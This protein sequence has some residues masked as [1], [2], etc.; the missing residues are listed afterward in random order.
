MRVYYFTDGHDLS[1]FSENN[2]MKEN[3]TKQQ[4]IYESLHIEKGGWYCKDVR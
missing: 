4:I 1:Y 3:F 2:F